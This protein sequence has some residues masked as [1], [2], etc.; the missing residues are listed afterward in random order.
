M[1]ESI[2]SSQYL[3]DKY[4]DVSS[5]ELTVKNHPLSS[6]ARL[7]LLKQYQKNGDSRLGNLAKQTSLYF[8]DPQW[9]SFQL[10][11]D[12][13]GEFIS[14]LADEDVDIAEDEPVL[15]EDP[16]E[17]DDL[18]SEQMPVI[19]T[20]PTFE[21]NDKIESI[22]SNRSENENDFVE[23]D[24]SPETENTLIAIAPDLSANDDKTENVPDVENNQG[25]TLT[26]RT[27]EEPIFEPLHA[28]DYFA[29]LG[30]TI[31]EESLANDKL[32]KQMKSFSEWMKSMKQL[33]PNK[34]PEQ[35]EVI[36]KIIQSSAEQS[37]IGSEILT[38]AMAEVLIK[39]NKQQK[40]IEM[41]EKLSLMN[42]SKSIYFAAKID[43]I[44]NK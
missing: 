17:S 1:N 7:L 14:E 29:S 37:N 10:L 4:D 23:N 26:E 24:S 2:N 13:S 35:N 19:N 16:F 11:R 21:E 18:G 25:K 5:L 22:D 9:L 6:F 8:N 15:N 3:Y 40:A 39:Q 42:P 43:K 36:E 38:E 12:E 27:K 30:V 20:E 34:M 28:T 33:H 41:Y 32:G 31:K 44:K